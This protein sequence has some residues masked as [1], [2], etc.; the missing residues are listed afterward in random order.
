[1]GPISYADFDSRPDDKKHD[2]DWADNINPYITSYNEGEV[3]RSMDGLMINNLDEK[4]ADPDKYITRYLTINS[5]QEEAVIKGLMKQI[6]D[7]LVKTG[8]V[9]FWDVFENQFI[10]GNLNG[11]HIMVI[12]AMKSWAQLDEDWEFKMHFEAL[13]GEG[14]YKVFRES[15][16]KVIKNHWQ[17]VIVVN[18]EMS[19]L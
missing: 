6:K 19:G 18:K 5:D 9:S 11:R 12:S 4:S 16:D 14:S 10:Q 3:W 2:D 17:E 8:K 1:M 15:Y 7:T 13:H